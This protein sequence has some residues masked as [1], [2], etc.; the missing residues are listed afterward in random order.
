M[1]LSSV[2]LTTTI[3][4][5]LTLVA[6]VSMMH[7]SSRRSKKGPA[8]VAEAASVSQTAS[9]VFVGTDHPVPVDPTSLQTTSAKHEL[10]NPVAAPTP[11]PSVVFEKNAQREV[12]PL[13]KEAREK[14]EWGREVAER[15][16]A[17][18]E[19]LYQKHLISEEAYQK[20]QAE[21]QQEIAKYEDQIAKYRSAGAQRRALFLWRFPRLRWHIYPR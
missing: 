16:R 13:S 1:I 6:S 17:Y 19:Y 5:A 4:G 3:A 14:L 12:E 20:G 7:P 10:S 15:E 11:Q 8:P 2:L 21:Y 18:V 9:P